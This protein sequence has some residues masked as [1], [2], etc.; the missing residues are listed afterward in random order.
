LVMFTV[1][2]R[3]RIRIDPHR[4]GYLNPDP[5]RDKKSWIR[6]PQTLLNTTCL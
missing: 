5:H 3:I 4:F 6:I 2:N 1:V